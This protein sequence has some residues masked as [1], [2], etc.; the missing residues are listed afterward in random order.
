MTREHYE[1]GYANKFNSLVEIDKFPEG[2]ADITKKKEV[3]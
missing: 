3:A 2:H 1:Q